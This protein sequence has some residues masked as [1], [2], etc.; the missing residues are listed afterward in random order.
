MT[1][2]TL[3]PI[4]AVD[5]VAL[6]QPQRFKASDFDL[7]RLCELKGTTTVSVCVPA[8]DEAETVGRSCRRSRPSAPWSRRRDRGDGRSQLGR[9]SPGRAAAGARVV[10]V[11]D[12]LP[13]A[14]TATGKGNALWAGVAA[15]AGDVIVWIDADLRSFSPDYVIGLI[16]PLLTDPEVTLVKASTTA[17]RPVAPAAGARPN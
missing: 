8:R 13:E 3:S 6:D 9:D 17:P 1:D 4:D 10:S 5:L 16:G 12:V 7:A 2:H 15:S 14:G 11:P